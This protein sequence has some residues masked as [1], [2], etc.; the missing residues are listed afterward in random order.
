[1]KYSKTHPTS[2]RT[3]TS[4]SDSSSTNKTIECTI[5]EDV[6]EKE[7]V[8]NPVTECDKNSKLYVII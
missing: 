1:M 5:V 4:T 2:K 6:T 7:H 3:R 8:R